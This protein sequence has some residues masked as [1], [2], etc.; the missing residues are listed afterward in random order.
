MISSD[1]VKFTVD[2]GKVD[3]KNMYKILL[4]TIL[5]ISIPSS[6]SS[7]RSVYEAIFCGCAVGITYQPY[8]D[9]LPLCMKKR[10][11]LIDLNNNNWFNLTYDL[12][13]KIINKKYIPSKEALET[14]STNSGCEYPRIEDPMPI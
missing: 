5:V 12:S 14:A 6:D 11:V 4:E 10:I 2:L 9:L 3:K 8:Y 13:K 1:T 7:P